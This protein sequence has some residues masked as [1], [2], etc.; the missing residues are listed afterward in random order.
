M[1]TRRIPHW[2]LRALV[3]AMAWSKAQRVPFSPYMA[4]KALQ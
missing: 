1:V 4:A 2:R 3:Q